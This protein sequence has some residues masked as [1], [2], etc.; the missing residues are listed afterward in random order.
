MADPRR[1]AAPAPPARSLR[2]ELLGAFMVALA[3]GLL[4]FLGRGI[5]LDTIATPE[6]EAGRQGLLLLLVAGVLL[7]PR[8]ERAT[9]SAR[10]LTALFVLGLVSLVPRPGPTVPLLGHGSLATRYPA[11][12]EAGLGELVRLGLLVFAALAAARTPR[13]WLVGGLVSGGVLVAL[14]G[15]VEYGHHFAINDRHWRIFAEFAN[16]NQFAAYL[17]AVAPLA[18]ALPERCPRVVRFGALGLLLVALALTGSKGA[19]LG[20]FLGGVAVALAVGRGNRRLALQVLGGLGLLLLLALLGPLRAR[21]VEH[22]AQAGSASFR[23]LTWRGTLA[24][25][26]HCPLLGTGLGGWA[27]GYPLY[28]QASFTQHAHSS[29][30]QVLAESG[31]GALVAL[32]GLFGL[33]WRDAW[34]A[35]RDDVQAA[36]VLAAVTAGAMAWLVDFGWGSAAGSAALV[37]AGASV[38]GPGSGR[39]RRWLLAV[40]GGLLLVLA[41]CLANGEGAR[42]AGQANMLAAAPGSAGEAYRRALA[43]MPWSAAVREDWASLA[44]AQGERDLAARLYTEAIARRTTCARLRYR[45]AAAQAAWGQRDQAVENALAAACLSPLH[46]QGWLQL[47]Q[48]YEER[49]ELD[50]ALFTYKRLNVLALSPQLQAKP[51]VG[52]QFTP[53]RAYALMRIADLLQR[54]GDADGAREARRRAVPEFEAY[55]QTYANQESLLKDAAETERTAALT[56]QGLTAA[57]REKVRTLLESARAAGPR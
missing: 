51:L 56:Q 6:V 7:Q 20:M 52:Y 32:V 30:L 37:L 1:Q 48:L 19:F 49:G 13:A 38:A 40:G 35:A 44:R 46:L 8:G 25:T 21:L 31:V 23:V 55:L 22:A 27:L 29:F 43:W 34:R 10:W 28:A 54:Q 12:A 33:W 14:S 45:L 2:P 17:V 3:A 9:G 15:V 36:A 26:A 57:E 41:T 42:A 53:T 47:G 4:P 11:D 39:D 18:L 5:H 24:L 16:P 50:E